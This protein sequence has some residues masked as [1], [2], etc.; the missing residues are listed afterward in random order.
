MRDTLIR[1]GMC[2]FTGYH[3]TNVIS[4][5]AQNW[6]H[7]CAEKF[8]LYSIKSCLL[9]GINGFSYNR[10]IISYNWRSHCWLSVVTVRHLCSLLYGEVTPVLLFIGYFS[11]RRYFCST[12]RC[13]F[14][15]RGSC[16]CVF[17]W[18]LVID[19]YLQQ[20]VYNSHLLHIIRL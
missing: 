2:I 11:L 4:V 20:N 19:G 12:C 10:T 3:R 17:V 7:E 15:W 5:H 16:T 8:V 18:V 9:K 6:Q 1:V 14:W 13:C